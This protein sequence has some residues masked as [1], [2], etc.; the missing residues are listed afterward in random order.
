ME[1]PAAMAGLV[2]TAAIRVKVGRAV[3]ARLTALPVARE[4]PVSRAQTILC[5]GCPDCL[6]C[7]Q[8][9]S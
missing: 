1:V 5:E 4:P 9:Y 7:W 2:A 3:Q 8:R 6:R